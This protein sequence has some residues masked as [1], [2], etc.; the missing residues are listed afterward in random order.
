VLMFALT[1]LSAQDRVT[2]L[3]VDKVAR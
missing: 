2:A 1:L 3:R